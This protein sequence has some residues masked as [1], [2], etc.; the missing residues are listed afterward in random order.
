MVLGSQFNSFLQPLV[1]MLSAPLCFI[2]AFAA[3][4]ISGMNL[5]IFG[6]ISLLAL[7]GLVMK[8]GILLVDYANQARLRGASARSA[9]L[10]AGP[11]RLRPVLA[12]TLATVFGMIPLTLS[13]ADAAEFRSPMGVLAIGGML[14]STILTLVVVPVV[15]GIFDDAVRL[16]EHLPVLLRRRRIVPS[17]ARGESQTAC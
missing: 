7:V 14:S 16:V 8:N 1:I 11:I 5:S 2:G 4:A 10:E 13:Q 15:Y 3:L 17:V 6:Q 9:M 12:T